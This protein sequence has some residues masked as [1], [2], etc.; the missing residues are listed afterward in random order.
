MSFDQLDEDAKKLLLHLYRKTGGNPSVQ[1]SMYEAGA[2]LGLDREAASRAAEDLIGWEMVELRTLAG[3]IGISDKAV[4]EIE[5]SGLGGSNQP[6]GSLAAFGKDV[7]I[8]A[9]ARQV[10]EQIVS[11]VKNRTG[12]LGL[13]FD[14]LS[15]V[16][17][18][19]KTIDAQLDSPRPK[20]AI[21]RECFRSLKA[22][23]DAVES[24][25]TVSR[26]GQLLKE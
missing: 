24:K 8:D 1:V 7:I 23:L 21:V 13:D 12:S 25:E 4:K 17:T 20:T 10:V 15:E 11:D 14:R 6:G 2:A 18:D 9:D 5:D 22:A 16:M 3:G 19:L 26:I